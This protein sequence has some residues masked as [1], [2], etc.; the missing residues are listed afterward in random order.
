VIEE[1]GLDP[2]EDFARPVTD[3]VLRGADVIV[4]MGHSVGLIDIPQGVRHE[5][6]RIGDPIGAPIDEIRRVR[7]DIEHR[8]RR[9]LAELG[10]PG[11]ERAVSGRV[12]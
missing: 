1:I 11:T 2:D 4:T 12:G 6:W 7:S 3:E 9:L 5:D 10:V 8:V